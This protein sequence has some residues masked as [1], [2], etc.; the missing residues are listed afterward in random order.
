MKHTIFLFVILISCS[1]NTNI[2]KTSD[3]F[4]ESDIYMDNQGNQYI[5]V[6]D[7]YKQI[8]DNLFQDEQ[9]NLYIQEV[10]HLIFD[11]SRPV[12]IDEI[13]TINSD[14]LLKIKDVVD[15]NTYEKLANTG[16]SR[17]KKYLYLL[18]KWSDR[19]EFHIVSNEPSKY[20][21]VWENC[22]YYLYFQ[23]KYYINQD[24]FTKENL[25]K[26]NTKLLK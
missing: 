20:N 13:Y 25:K 8:K 10:N 23:G 16:F 18:K 24:V 15:K 3:A 19:W 9:G 6:I 1:E 4:F 22:K 5:K 21:L 2:K 7:S 17:D 14:K 26:Q 12:Y 11:Y